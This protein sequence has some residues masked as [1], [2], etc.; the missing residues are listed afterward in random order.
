MD[1]RDKQLAIKE[2]ICEPSLTFSGSI[3]SSEVM[4]QSRYF[5]LSVF[6]CKKVTLPGRKHFQHETL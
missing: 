4:Q 6:P 5:G 1:L 2:I 3:S